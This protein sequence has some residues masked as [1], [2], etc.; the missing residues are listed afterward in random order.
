LRILDR[1][2]VV[3]GIDT[4][5]SGRDQLQSRVHGRV[6]IAG[7]DG[8]DQSRSVFNAMIDRY[9]AL[10]IRCENATDVVQ[11]VNFARDHGL[12]VSVKGGGHSVAGSA[13]GD[14]GVMLDM[15][16]MTRVVVDPAQRLAVA[17]SGALLAQLDAATA[18]HGL[19]TPLGV[20]SVTG[21]AGLTLGGGLGWLNGKH[22]L[23]CDN[24]VGVDIVIADGRLLTASAEQNPDLFWAVRGGG[25]NFG[26]VVSFTY[27]LHPVSA[28]LAG[29]IVYPSGM[30]AEALSHFHE[31]ASTAPDEL[32]T[33]ASLWRDDEGVTMASVGVCWSGRVEDGELA[34]RRLRE[35]GPPVADE[36]RPMPYA[37]LQQVSDG[38]FPEGRQHY[39]KA[40]FLKN[41]T[42]E[43]IDVVIDHLEHA[44]SPYTGVGFQ[45]M[46]GVASRVEPSATAFAHRAKQYDCL[47]LSQWDDPADSP[48]NIAWTRSLFED[49]TPFLESGVYVNNL[50][51]G[52]QERAHA[53]FGENYERLSRI[54][55]AYDP[56]NLFRSNANIETVAS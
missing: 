38:G 13:V 22:G 9:P 8:Y 51:D 1:E 29:A 33:S 42:A 52:E 50:G 5:R 43:L 20:V 10:V 11:G 25:G 27:R 47:I 28:V 39:W 26:V 23:A 53:A 14:D 17:E 34:L 19:A 41:L 30:A 15:S 49:M 45:Q 12:P 46:T 36:V 24:L 40:S 4:W 37:A 44:P 18:E 3:A 31:V 2:V 55:A 56:G 32:S 16:A 7:V 21:I 54:K 48:A 35:F 6:L